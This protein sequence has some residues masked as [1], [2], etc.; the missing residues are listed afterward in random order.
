MLKELKPC[1]FCGEA[2]AYFY[3][4]ES[5]IDV[6]CPKCNLVGSIIIKGSCSNIEKYDKP[7]CNIPPKFVASPSNIEATRYNTSE[8]TWTTEKPHVAGWY[9][10]RPIDTCTNK[11]GPSAPI[12]YVE[13]SDILNTLQYGE[14]AGP[15]SEQEG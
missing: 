4:Y 9:W 11:P 3:K 5:I 2:D 8:L 10:F 13:G 6:I 7:E 1:P 12:Y 15:I 14:F